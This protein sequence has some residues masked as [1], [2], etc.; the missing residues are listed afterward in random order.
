LVDE[1][2]KEIY[3]RIPYQRVT[4]SIIGT[5]LGIRNILY[6]YPDRIPKTN[7]VIESNKETVEQFN[8]RKCNNI[9]KSFI[10]DDKPIQLWKVQKIAGIDSSEFIRIK[11]KLN[12][13][14]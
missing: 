9:I 10:N 7:I 5:E 13:S 12:F 1:K 11:N 6:K 2:Y 3:D 8:I 4:K 14:N